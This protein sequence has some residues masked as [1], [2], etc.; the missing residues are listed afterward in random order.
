MLNWKMLFREL[1]QT[2]NHEKRRLCAF[3]GCGSVL[4]IARFASFCLASRWEFSYYMV[5]PCQYT[6]LL[7]SNHQCSLVDTCKPI[8]Q[9]SLHCGKTYYR[10]ATAFLWD[11]GTNSPR[12]KMAAGIRAWFS[13]DNRFYHTE[14]CIGSTASTDLRRTADSVSRYTSSMVPSV[15]IG[16][17]LLCCFDK[18]TTERQAKRLRLGAKPF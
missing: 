17:S 12:R 9:A 13:T 7:H 3:N 14:L 15:M 16:N 10:A 18:N 5:L 1:L 11:P 6:N 4:K 2:S 8:D